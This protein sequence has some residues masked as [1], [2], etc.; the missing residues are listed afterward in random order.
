MIKK[1]ISD[2]SDKPIEGIKKVGKKYYLLNSDSDKIF[3]SI[4][5]EVEAVGLF[6]GEDKKENFYPSLALLD[7]L[8]KQ[9]N[10]KMTVD[11][12]A[13]WLF[14]CGR[15]IM[16]KSIMKSDVFMGI[17]LVQNSK[18]ENLGI[19]RIVGDIKRSSDKIVVKNIIDKGDYLRREMDGKKK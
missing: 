12:K 3:G 4:K 14:V 8:S 7:I 19:G 5:L 15:D 6:L 17:V 2:F 16:A 11:D 10:R 18:N 9:S 1:F 13:A